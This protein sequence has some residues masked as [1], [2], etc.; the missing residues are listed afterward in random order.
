MDTMPA[1]IYV[2]DGAIE[3]RE[4]PVPEPGP[5]EALVAISHCGICGTDLHLVLEGMG[6]PGSGL[7]HE[8]AGTL[9]A[10]GDGVTGWELG[11]RVVAGP[12]PGCGECRACRHG[13]PSVCLRREPVD[14][15]E[16]RGAFARYVK[17]DAT[18]LLRIPESLSTRAAALTEPTAVALHAVSLSGVTPDDHV[19]VTGAGPVGMLITAVLAARGVRDVTVS[20]PAA[21]RRERA[22]TVGARRVVTP[23]ELATAHPATPVD[24]AYSVVFECSGRA[25]AAESALDQLDFAGTF[26]F[27]GTGSRYPRINHN[28][29]IIL[30]STIL[31]AFN[32]DAEGFGPALDL[33]ASGA[34]PL[35][36]L[37]EPDDVTLDGL[38]GVM[39]R[40]AAGELPGKVMIVP[41]VAR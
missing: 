7:G 40:C 15:L 30:E 37:I 23:D 24:D 6:R 34:M 36:A 3:V 1:T 18:R 19:L 8:W 20:E 39:Q 27:V 12:K 11:A 26:V 10:V 22:L 25:E 31:G 41:E 2:G 16:F 4:V 9:A 32:Y 35:D 38:L 13:R 5:G 33:L 28:R 29:A 17:V 14:Y 21:P